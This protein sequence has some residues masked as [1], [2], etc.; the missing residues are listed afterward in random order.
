M[1]I[2]QVPGLDKPDR[3]AALFFRFRYLATACFECRKQQAFITRFYTAGGVPVNFSQR[4]P[5][6]VIIVFVA[7]FYIRRRGIGTKRLRGCLTGSQTRKS[8]P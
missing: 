4:E 1:F 8:Y 3:Q 7:L 6:V 2:I 5:P